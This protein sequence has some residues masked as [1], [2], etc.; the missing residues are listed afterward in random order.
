MLRFLNVHRTIRRNYTIDRDLLQ[1]IDGEKNAP[2]PPPP[3]KSLPVCLQRSGSYLYWHIHKRFEPAKKDATTRTG[4]PAKT[5]ARS[6]Q[7][8]RTTYSCARDG[9]SRP[10]GLQAYTQH[11][12]RVSTAALTL[13]WSRTLRMTGTWLYSSTLR[14]PPDKKKRA[15]EA[16]ARNNAWARR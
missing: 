11:V 2:L 16:V 4:D 10:F 5:P 13:S 9:V 15:K 1:R 6:A 12:Q 14:V 7:G 8:T 3:P